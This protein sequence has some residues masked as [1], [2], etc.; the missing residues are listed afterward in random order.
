M[1]ADFYETFDESPDKGSDI[2]QEVLDILSQELPSTFA[3][4]KNKDGE[5]IAGPK[6]E[7]LSEPMTLK[8]E[9]DPD[10]VREHLKDIPRD[11]WAEYIYRMQLRVPV[12]SAKIGDREKQIP[13]ENTIGNPLNNHAEA[14]ENF[15]LPEAF[16][17]A[18]EVL[19]ETE[20]GDK[21]V[22]HVA[23]K[24]YDSMHEIL[25]ANVDFPA[26]QI[27]FI[28]ADNHVDSKVKY[29]VTPTAA[30]SVSEALAAIRLFKGFYNGTA[31]IEG[32]L[33]GKPVFE[34]AGMDEEQLKQS[35]EFWTIAQK[36]EEKLGVT[37]D[38]GA[39]FSM[40]DAELFFN[41]DCC[42]LKDKEVVWEHPFDHF[43]VSGIDVKKGKFYDYL[44]KEGV[45]FVFR[46]G[47]I[48]GT[49]LGAE[50]DLY[51]RTKM[52]N[53]VMTN[54]VWD[55]DEKNAGEIYVSDP[56]GSKWKLFRKYMTEESMEMLEKTS[57]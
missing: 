32:K 41:L 39:E 18:K 23:R 17:P 51:S 31:K 47:P 21:I 20:E 44:G 28:L 9:I 54:I 22:M 14:Y 3:Y 37:F 12:K 55:N 42:L 1:I 26:I 15:M 33:V 2:P 24:P 6:P 46:E 19:F 10:F 50:L 48:H 38:P 45:E 34:D 7:H 16:P 4:Y 57:R 27:Q 11:K 56:V 30:E 40:E 29:T 36:L 52:S 5:Y 8:I 25:L 49:L 43:H 53:I 13:I 35:E